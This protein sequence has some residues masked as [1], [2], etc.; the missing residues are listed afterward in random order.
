MIIVLVNGISVWLSWLK[1]RLFVYQDI[2]WTISKTLFSIPVLSIWS[3]FLFFFSIYYYEA[4]TFS[5]DSKQRLAPLTV[6]A[7]RFGLFLFCAF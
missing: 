6:Q 2:D 5:A 1:T 7:D 4:L 3:F